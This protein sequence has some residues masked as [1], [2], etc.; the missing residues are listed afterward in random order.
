MA[1]L[2]AMLH[3]RLAPSLNNQRAGIRFADAYTEFAAQME[4]AGLEPAP[5]DLQSPRSPN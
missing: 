3:L 5:S 1:P 2:R 4:P